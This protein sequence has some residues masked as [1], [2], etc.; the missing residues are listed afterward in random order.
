MQPDFNTRYI[1]AVDNPQKHFTI[2][3][4]TDLVSADRS[5]NIYNKPPEFVMGGI[6]VSNNFPVATMEQERSYAQALSAGINGD[7]LIIGHNVC[8]DLMPL[9]GFMNEYVNRV[10]LWDTQLAE[11]L[12]SGQTKSKQTLKELAQHY[13][14]E[15][16]KDDEV[17]DMIREG[18]SPKDIPVDVLTKYLQ[19]DVATTYDIFLCQREQLLHSHSPNLPM[20]R[21]IEQMRYLS[22]THLASCQGFAVDLKRADKILAGLDQDAG[23]LEYTICHKMANIF[24]GKLVPNPA[25]VAQWKAI[26]YGGELKYSERVQTGEVYKTGTKA[27]QPKTK[28]VTKTLILKGIYCGAN[29]PTK[30]ASEETLKFIVEHAASPDLKTLLLNL[31]DLRTLHKERQTYYEGYMGYARQHPRETINSQY[32]HTITPTGRISSSK[33]NLQN[34]KGED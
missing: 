14:T 21:V 15:H 2:D 25:S 27:G 29:P 9:N 16:Q 22:N 26:L 11:Y 7:C 34:I 13:N 1:A 8:F 20:N 31:L 19:A 4:E 23:L 18:I 33:P 6:K 5:T 32:N 17:G 10:L 3:I 30:N 24:E 12:I 28:L